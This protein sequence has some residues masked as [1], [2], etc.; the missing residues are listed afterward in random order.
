VVNFT[1]PID[2]YKTRLQVNPQFSVGAM[3]REEGVASLYKGIAPAWMREAT[4]TSM[5]VRLR[6]R[7]R[8]RLH[9]GWLGEEERQETRPPTGPPSAAHHRT[10]LHGRLTLVL[11]ALSLALLFLC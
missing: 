11:F 9:L 10:A 7:L 2:T 1:H 8:L 5:K 4:Y 3:V 6:L